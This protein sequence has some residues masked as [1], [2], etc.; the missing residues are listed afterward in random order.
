MNKITKKINSEAEQFVIDFFKK[1]DKNSATFFHTLSHTRYV[2]D[3]VIEIGKAEGL[4][5]ELI[6]L[7]TFCAWFHDIG[8]IVV[9]KV[10]QED[11]SIKM[12]IDFLKKKNIEQE[13][14]NKVKSCIN[15]T[16][17]PQNPTDLVSKVLCDADMRHLSSPDYFEII[18]KLRNELAQTE[19]RKIR[20]S[21][22]NL[23]NNA[24]LT[25]HQ[26]FTKYGQDVLSTGKLKNIKLLNEKI[27]KEILKKNDKLVE[28]ISEENEKLKKKLEKPKGYSRGVESMFR[29][30]ARNQI[31]LSSIA[32]NKSNILITVNSII[33]SI[34]LTV[35]VN[36]FDD[37]PSLIIPTLIFLGFSL[38]TI[39][40]AILS[41]RPNISS[42]RFTKEDIK[43]NKVN[44][45]FFGSFYNM[46]F[47]DYD[48]A[49]QELMH[50]DDNLYSI[51]TKDQYL[52]GKVLA[53][54]YKLLRIAYNIFMIGIII[55]VVAFIFAHTGL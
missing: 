10:Y 34:S 31:S 2:V 50:N 14:I 41:T 48:W 17:M 22:F 20:K 30:T 32:D 4:S 43:Q 16:R 35:L 3:G 6:D 38:A 18:E 24:F 47:D 25:H 39:I 15:S 33:I 52:L 26:Y 37:K 36:R 46:E 28:K 12:A 40:F 13:Q 23:L 55:S 5:T 54:K 29:L 1:N 45:L 42:G 21:H 51:M 44:L 11:G 7:L 19:N 27:E 8:N 9:E 53:K 49:I